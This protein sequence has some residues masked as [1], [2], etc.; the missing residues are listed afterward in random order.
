MNSLFE[1]CVPGTRGVTA[2]QL[3]QRTMSGL[4][5]DYVYVI[6]LDIHKKRKTG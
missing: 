1:C 6:G 2:P 4:L 3:I 5:R